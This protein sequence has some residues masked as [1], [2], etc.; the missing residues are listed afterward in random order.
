MFER[1]KRTGD[2]GTAVADRPVT[3]GNGTT[4]TVAAPSDRDRSTARSGVAQPFRGANATRDPRPAT[5]APRRAKSEERSAN[6][7]AR[8]AKRG[9]VT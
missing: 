2:G 1:F 6:S 4:T 8:T 9:F 3:H 5:R 7:E